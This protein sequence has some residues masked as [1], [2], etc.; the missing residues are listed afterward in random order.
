MQNPLAGWRGWR[1]LTFFGENSLIISAYVLL[2]HL[3]TAIH[4][5]GE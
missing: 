4:L 2:K 5:M 3:Q 1:G